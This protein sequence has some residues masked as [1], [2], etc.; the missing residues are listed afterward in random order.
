MEVRGTVPAEGGYLLAANHVSWLDP[1]ALGSAC[2]RQIRFVI[3]RAI[4]DDPKQ[5]WFYRGMRTIPI[6]DEG[7]ADQR[8][9]REAIRALRRGELVGIFPEGAGLDP[10]GRPR[11]ARGGAAV[12]ARGARVPVIPVAIEGTHRALP[13]G[14]LVPRPV[15]LRVTFGEPFLPAGGAVKAN[16]ARL[17]LA[18]EMMRRILALQAAP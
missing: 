3:A 9:L 10:E 13:K 18:D 5:R 11:V 6:R 2:P 15:R 14:R 8:A 4:Y 1:A 12:L 7:A 17:D 16:V